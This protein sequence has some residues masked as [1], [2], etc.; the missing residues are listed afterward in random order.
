MI[1]VGPRRVELAVAIQSRPQPTHDHPDVIGAV[2]AR[3][4]EVVPDLGHGVPWVAK[5]LTGRFN[6][7]RVV[8]RRLLERGE[9][10]R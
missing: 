3:R 10:V 5:P 6:F 4:V 1:F 2:V 7:V 9:G 8:H